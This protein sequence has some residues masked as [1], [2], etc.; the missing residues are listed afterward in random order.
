M[1]QLAAFLL[2]SGADWDQKDMGG[3]TAAQIAQKKELVWLF[4]H[5]KQRK[6]ASM[7]QSAVRV[8]RVARRMTE[9]MREKAANAHF[10]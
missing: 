2:A 3:R 9:I 8:K 1:Q 4:G 6:S 7:L 10:P 5:I